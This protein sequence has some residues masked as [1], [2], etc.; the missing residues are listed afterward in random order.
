MLTLGSCVNIR[1]YKKCLSSRSNLVS[2]V[3]NAYYKRQG[4]PVYFTPNGCRLAQ[5]SEVYSATIN[6]LFWEPQHLHWLQLLISSPFNFLS[7]QFAILPPTYEEIRSSNPLLETIILFLPFRWEVFCCLCLQ[8]QQSSFRPHPPRK[9]LSLRSPD[10][11]ASFQGSPYLFSAT[12]DTF[13]C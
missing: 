4:F 1:T 6:G 3:V 5:C 7:A 13:P 2:G 10:S 8:P 12:T 9:L 11:V